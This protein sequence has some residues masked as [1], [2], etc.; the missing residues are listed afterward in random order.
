MTSRF[1]TGFVAVF[2]T[3]T[4]PPVLAGQT[5]VSGQSLHHFYKFIDLGTFGGPNSRNDGI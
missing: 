3:L 4:L 1:P 2:M 5:T